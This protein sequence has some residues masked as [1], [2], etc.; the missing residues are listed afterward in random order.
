MEDVLEQAFEGGCPWRQ[1]SKLWQGLQGWILYTI[2][3]IE[4]LNCLEVTNCSAAVLAA[5]TEEIVI[6]FNQSWPGKMNWSGLWRYRNIHQNSFPF[7]EWK[8]SVCILFF[9]LME[10]HLPRMGNCYIFFIYLPLLPFYLPKLIVIINQFSNL[11]KCNCL[12]E[13]GNT[14]HFLTPLLVCTECFSML[15]LLN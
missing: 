4:I 12:F 3:I 15:Y 1:H 10:L 8:F 7:W 6:H 11:Y 14:C 2:L 5:K 13:Q 9:I